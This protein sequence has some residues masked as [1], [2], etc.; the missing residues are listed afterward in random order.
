M[1]NAFALTEVA[2]WLTHAFDPL[3]VVPG[4]ATPVFS[5]LVLS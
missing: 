4:F 5:T 1:H 2:D 3:A